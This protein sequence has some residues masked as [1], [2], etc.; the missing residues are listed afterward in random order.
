MLLGQL[1]LCIILTRDSEC[2]PEF[3]YQWK[4]INCSSETCYNLRL[5][6]TFAS[7]IAKICDLNSANKPS[8]QNLTK[9]LFAQCSMDVKSA[10]IENVKNDRPSDWHA[11]LCRQVLLLKCHYTFYMYGPLCRKAFCRILKSCSI[12]WITSLNV[13]KLQIFAIFKAKVSSKLKEAV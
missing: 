6:D 3:G 4:N 8:F 10:V 5:L 2:D 11:H 13:Q 12:S 1:L 7:K 9:S